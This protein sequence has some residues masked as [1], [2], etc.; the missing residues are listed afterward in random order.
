MHCQTYSDNLLKREIPIRDVAAAPEA[1]KT[2]K[3]LA[4]RGFLHTNIAGAGLE[5]AT[6]GL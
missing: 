3:P 5:P 1:E 4:Q 6:S 2:T